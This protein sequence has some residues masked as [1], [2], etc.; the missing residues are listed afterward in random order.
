M[1]AT[2]HTFT[3]LLDAIERLLGR[4]EP[5]W[6]LQTCYFSVQF[7]RDIGLLVLR[8]LPTVEQARSMFQFDGNEFTAPKARLGGHV[9]REDGTITE[10]NWMPPPPPDPPIQSNESLRDLGDQNFVWRGYGQNTRGVIKLRVGR[11]LA[12]V[13]APSIDDAERLARRVA[14]LL[15]GEPVRASGM[16]AWAP[17]LWALVVPV[18]LVSLAYIVGLMLLGYLPGFLRH[19]LGA[20]R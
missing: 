2:P 3:D 12:D 14:A 11:F 19:W 10:R 4:D 13:N 7:G 16:R 20:N 9:I 8:I 15:G 1:P 6:A 17:H 18:V 5:G